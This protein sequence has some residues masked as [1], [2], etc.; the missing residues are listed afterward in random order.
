MVWVHNDTPQWVAVSSHKEYLKNHRDKIQWQDGTH[1]KVVYH[2]DEP[3]THAFRHASDDEQA[4]NHKGAWQLPKLV[5]WEELGDLRD[6][7]VSADFGGAKL[8]LK[9]NDDTFATNLANA[10]PDEVP[11]DPKA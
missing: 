1:A 4:E 9:D 3:I 11:F 6:K 8:A 7:L 2:K 10:K 5:G